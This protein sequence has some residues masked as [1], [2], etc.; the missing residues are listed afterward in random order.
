MR[1]LRCMCLLVS[2]SLLGCFCATSALA[3]SPWWHVTSNVRPEILHGEGTVV[4]EAL[5]V[6]NEATLGNE[7]ASTAAIVVTDTLPA[8]VTV[9]KVEVNPGEPEPKVSFVATAQTPGLGAHE[10]LRFQGPGFGPTQEFSFEHACTEPTVRVVRC[11]YPEGFSVLVP[12]E[13][14]EM[15]IAVTTEA[16][17]VSGTNLVEVSGGGVAPARIERPLPIDAGTPSFG[18]EEFTAVPE[19]E[20]GGIDAQAGSHPYQL[21]TAVALNQNQDPLKAPAL[22]RS[23]QF[24]LPAGLVGNASAVAQCTETQFTHLDGGIVDFCPNDTAIG[25][26]TFTIDEPV[27]GGVQTISI[28]VFNLTPGHGEPARFGFEYVGTPIILDPS[29]RTGSDYGVTVAAS[30]FTQVANVISSTVTFWGVPGDPSHD[31]S[32]GWGC[33]AG[34]HW[35]AQ[36]GLE[37]TPLHESEPKPFLRMPT[38]CSAPFA[39]S[40]TGS[41]WPLRATPSSQPETIALPG[42]EYSLRDSFGQ[43]LGITGCNQLSF[44]PSIEVAANEHD[45]SS[46]T[47]LSVNVRVPQE[48]DESPLGLGPSDVKDATVTLPEGVTVN[49]AAAGGLQ[50]CSESQIGFERRESSGLYRFSAGSPLSSCP[51]QAKV[52]TVTIKS[53]LLPA[54]QVVE[55][56]VY[57]A[58]QDENPFGSLIA[59]YI[60]AENPIEGVR[61]KLPMDVSLNGDTGQLTS[62]LENSPQLPFEEATFHFFAGPRA[63]LAT[64]THCGSYKTGASF[65]PWSGNPAVQSSSSFDVSSGPDGSPCPGT[66]PFSPTLVSGVTNINAGAFSPLTTTISREDGN[67]ELQT[68]QLHLPTGLEAILA[69]VKL[70]PEAQ[71]NAGTC[72]QESLIGHSTASVGVG[73]E[74][75]EVTGGEVFLTESFESAPFGLSIVTPA[76][77]GPYNLGKVIVRAKLQVDP[78][79]AAVTVTT[80]AIPHILQGIP[81][82]IRAATVTIDR[83]GFT[84]NPTDC[85]QLG[86]TGSVGSV[87]GASAGVSEPLEVANCAKLKFAPKFELSTTAKTS[88]VDGASLTTKIFYPP[89]PP[90]PQETEYTNISSVKVDLPK[91]LPSRL[92]TLQK[93]CLASVFEVNPAN[94]PAAS[95]VGHAK[96]ITPILPVPLTGPAYFVSHGNEAFPSLTMVLQGYG[97]TI[98]L[99][100]STFIK[101]GV[102]SS[103]FK[104]TPDAPLTMFELTLPRG[105]FSALAANGNLCKAKLN[106]PNVFNAQNGLSLRETSKIKVTGCPKAKPKHAPKKRKKKR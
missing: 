100:G 71:A 63:P 69:G 102:T 88:K 64:P 68:V 75:F 95:I 34:E 101:K 25:V 80:G 60:V 70:C 54:G 36:A 51:E 8:G 6:G 21:T 48:S 29:V 16:N 66:L 7:G 45:A 93:A 56:S 12:F 24:R 72:G 97:V 42:A 91:A 65:T 44:D 40:V 74:P 26:A 98:D 38:S 78:H 28:P 73:S 49:P 77:A 32:R 3:S 94:C 4:A 90:G 52:G 89:T 82:R 103:T 50:A 47:G 86:I 18:I 76:V 15:G 37:C 57:V 83:P 61:V 106:V 99:V 5:N 20:G 23:F 58:A 22:A 46:P 19:R 96:V 79:T 10:E 59:M 35:A 17:A 41:S 85:N 39:I 27:D 9:D 33:L 92:T 67:Q 43:P 104:S 62:T 55:G 84:F 14:L 11:V 30:N 13:F 2:L 105:P 1:T 81:L 31:K 87:E 53:P